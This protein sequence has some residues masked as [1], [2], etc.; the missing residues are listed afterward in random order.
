MPTGING[1]FNATNCSRGSCSCTLQNCSCLCF[2]LTIHSFMH[3]TN[4]SV[5]RAIWDV[6]KYNIYII[7][8]KKLNYKSKYNIY[9]IKY[10]IYKWG[11]I[12]SWYLYFQVHCR[13]RVRFFSSLQAFE[14]GYTFPSPKTIETVIQVAKNAS[15]QQEYDF[16][17]RIDF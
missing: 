12:I 1:L 11:R 14:F 5:L 3:K 2:P 16:R 17:K 15:L 8:V 4:A 6:S 10:A 9:I 7:K 13:Q